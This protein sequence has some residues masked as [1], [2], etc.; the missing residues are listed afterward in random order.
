LPRP[1]AMTQTIASAA[2]PALRTKRRN[3][4]FMI[5]AS[6]IFDNY[7]RRTQALPGA[8]VGSSTIPITAI[9]CP[10]STIVFMGSI[11]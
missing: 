1:M 4:G 7:F 11:E 8:R 5:V 6:A 2:R 9:Q 3:M 10:R